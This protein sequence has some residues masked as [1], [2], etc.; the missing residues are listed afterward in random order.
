MNEYERRGRQLHGCADR[1][2]RI[3]GRNVTETFE[4]LRHA[5]AAFGIRGGKKNEI[6]KERMKE[7]N[8]G[9]CA[10]KLRIGGS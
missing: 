3:E 9:D 2:G 7:T 1:H 4:T 8:R 6:N 10:N 5:N